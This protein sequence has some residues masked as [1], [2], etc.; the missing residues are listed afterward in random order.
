M[1]VIIEGTDFAF[2]APDT[3]SPGPTRF[4]FQRSGTVAHEMA[5]ARVKAG[6]TLAPE[7]VARLAYIEAMLFR[8]L[9]NV[10]S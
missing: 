5:I 3:M 8:T 7:R 6:T 4:R 2:V 9:A 1:T 10:V